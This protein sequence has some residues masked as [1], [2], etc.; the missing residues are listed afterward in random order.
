MPAPGMT[1]KPMYAHINVFNRDILGPHFLKR[2]GGVVEQPYL[3]STIHVSML[4]PF[5][6]TG[7]L[8]G[9]WF[10]PWVSSGITQPGRTF[11]GRKK[12]PLGCTRLRHFTFVY[13]VGAISN[14]IFM[15]TACEPRIC[16]GAQGTPPFSYR[17]PAFFVHYTPQTI[18]PGRL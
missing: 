15:H 2:G 7:F 9:T 10:Q 3:T 12:P 14:S 5:G 16:T 13:G 18:S 17:I 4:L 11:I 6:F 8:K 1:T